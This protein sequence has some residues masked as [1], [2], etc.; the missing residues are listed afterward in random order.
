MRWS[1]SD[2]FRARIRYD[3]EPGG[4]CVFGHTKIVGITK[5]DPELIEEQLT[6]KSGESFDSR[7]LAASRGA[8]VGLNVFSAVD[9][10]QE[11]NPGDRAIVPILISVHEGPRHTLSAGAVTTPRPN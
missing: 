9:I 7:K 6:Y 4:R 10:E 2:H 5:V 11:D 3:V 1:S 8:I